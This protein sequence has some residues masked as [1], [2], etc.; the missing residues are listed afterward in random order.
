[1]AKKST[2]AIGDI[3][4]LAVESAT[5][6]QHVIVETIGMAY[7]LR[8]L[9]IDLAASDPALVDRVRESLAA[10]MGQHAPH[11]QDAARRLLDSIADPSG[12]P[13]AML[14]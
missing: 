6:L 13:A 9:V 2:P 11:I 8:S 5:T 3:A 4:A 7:I 12:R 14:Q 1:M 10:D